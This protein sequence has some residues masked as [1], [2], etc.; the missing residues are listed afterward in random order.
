M[1]LR[2]SKEANKSIPQFPTSV[3]NL[4]EDNPNLKTKMTPNGKTHKINRSPNS[5]AHSTKEIDR[6]NSTHSLEIDSFDEEPSSINHIKDLKKPYQNGKSQNEM[7]ESDLNYNTTA[8][9]KIFEALDVRPHPQGSINSSKQ[10][11]ISK[12]ILTQNQLSNEQNVVRKTSGEKKIR[13]PSN[14]SKES[15]KGMEELYSV[16]FSEENLKVRVHD[17]SLES[18]REMTLERKKEQVKL[19]AENIR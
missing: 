2:K 6:I 18:P 14:A 9:E 11:D 10:R 7:T 17:A 8:G 16:G 13:K 3:L 4:S 12:K 15:M 19:L 5:E 1:N